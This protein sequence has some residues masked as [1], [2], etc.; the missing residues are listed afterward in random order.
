M[1]LDPP[2]LVSLSSILRELAY[3]SSPRLLLALRPQDPIP[4]WT[5]HLVILGAN[6]TVALMGSKP[7][8]L[9]AL[10]RWREGI[11]QVTS[12]VMVRKMASMMT[13]SFGTPPAE[14]GMSLTAEGVVP[15]EA[16]GKMIAE[17]EYFD[18]FGR[19]RRAQVSSERQKEF[20]AAH[21]KPIAQQTLSDLLILTATP[22]SSLEN[23]VPIRTSA[24]GKFSSKQSEKARPVSM[25]ALSSTLE[26]AVMGE[27]LI[28]LSGIVVKYGEKV[29]L[30]APAQGKLP[31]SS[32]TTN[33][34]PALHLTIRQGTRLALLGP[35]G[36]GKTT[37]L[38]LLTSDHP[39]S[40]SLPI[41]FFGRSRLPSP[42]RPGL[43][44][45]DI[46][47]RIGHSSPE[48][49]AF[50][51]THLSVRRVLESAWADT[52]S[53][54][55]NLTFERDRLVDAMLRWWEPELRG[56]RQPDQ[57][58]AEL[59][60]RGPNEG[61]P[62]TGNVQP[63]F[64]ELVSHS[65]PPPIGPRPETQDQLT[66]DKD[67]DLEWAESS[68]PSST[69]G[70]LPIGTQRLLL[71]LR[72]II[73]SP[74]ILILDE[75]FSGLSPEVRDK[76]ML[77]LSRGETAF[78]SHILPTYPAPRSR[79]PKESEQQRYDTAELENQ[80]PILE[81]VARSVGF[82]DATAL[83]LSR[84]SQAPTKQEQAMYKRIS[85]M[86]RDELF[87][88]AAQYEAANQGRSEMDVGFGFTGLSGRQ[89]LVVVSHVKE[90]VPGIVNEWLRLPG[91][92]EI[93]ETG[94]GVEMGRCRE[95][96][97]RTTRGWRRV[98]GF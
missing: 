21:K 22:P 37:L 39:H 58:R 44:L 76:A 23:G 60:A 94:R 20:S 91:E 66:L 29:V 25:S 9:F 43:S 72:A 62:P 52:F 46:Q 24:G 28:E 47:S 14:F 34:A 16:Y 80:R 40:Y 69:F 36:S 42:G 6:Y 53:A 96:A 88:A 49:H 92:E 98:W 61:R 63:A 79:Q 17:S 45:W 73:K 75:A 54:K 84:G 50:F 83:V 33:P 64:W 86:T 90:E 68:S 4:D 2:T 41:K 70:G 31:R 27:P 87:A 32:S 15:Y 97:I 59:L 1:G 93:L 7:E 56:I 11:N 13:E 55:P 8:V 78:Y 77:F 85:Q 57:R 12:K 30:G 18:V 19:I 35:N 10:H 71:L 82:A 5:T 26:Q 95:G 81:R 51:P 65:S 67:T 3:K 48:I 74:D 38:S 89:A